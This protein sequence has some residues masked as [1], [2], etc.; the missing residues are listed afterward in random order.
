MHKDKEESNK[1][2]LDN[3]S[4]EAKRVTWTGFF[5]NVFLSAIKLLAGILGRS[6]AMV[7]DAIHSFSDFITDVIV[8]VFISLSSRERDHNHHWGHGKFET[9]ASF[10]ISAILII[11]GVGIL[12]N[13]ISDVISSLRGG[14]I[15][16][17][18]MI[19]LW[20]AVVSILCKE[21]LFHYT[22]S[23]GKAIKSEA[24]KAN[25]WHH[26]SDAFSSIGT[27]LGIAGAIFLGEK[28]R[29][30]DPVASFVVSIFIIL[31]GVRI[32]KP[33]LEELL[34]ASLSP[35]DEMDIGFI[36]ANTRG[37][38]RFH[39]LRTRK[40]GINSIID[41]HIKVDCDLTVTQ[42]HQ[43]TVD[44]EERLRD[45]FDGK[46]ISSIHVEPDR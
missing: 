10:I 45:H 6:S 3:R 8:I 9:F 30:L 1:L 29:I 7:A 34:D 25:A 43:I 16:R 35:R 2:L 32:I 18:S 19:A 12:Y 44:L 41:V 15:E 42:S 14:I 20:A 27:A 4:R 22:Y 46:V 37:V 23:K 5:V 31:S 36:I 17:P 11:V 24:V 40:N 13:G 28:W 33:A 39:N 38:K 26:R 21:V